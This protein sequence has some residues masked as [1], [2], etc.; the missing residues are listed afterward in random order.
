MTAGPLALDALQAALAT[1]PPAR[2]AAVG[3]ALAQA[4]LT[5]RAVTACFGVAA[6][7]H[8]PRAVAAGR[9]FPASPPPA[10][11]APWLL[12]AGGAVTADAAAAALG[13]ALPA[14]DAAGLVDARDGRVRARVT[15]LPAGSALAVADRWDHLADDAVTPPDDSSHHLVAAL[16]ARRVDRWL[17]LATGAAWAPLAAAGR[18]R[19][20]V[21]ADVAPR[22]IAL[23]RL[24]AALSGH[25][26]DLR[27]T[28]LADGIP[29]RF[30]L[31]T[32]N[33]PIP[34]GTPAA[35]PGEP[36]HRVGGPGLAARLWTTL[37]RLLAPGGEAV[38][39]TAL[40]GDAAPPSLPGELVIARYTPP[41]HP[42]FGV[43]A[44]R[45]ER[46]AGRRVVE[47]AL[48]AAQPHAP[49]AALE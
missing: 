47:V 3:A 16:P 27:V 2:W 24:G 6:V 19:E 23:A 29:G 49:R 22:A 43:V 18:A 26:L 46:P 21:A 32:A 35:R 28:D 42:A 39:H 1:H 5:G 40:E 30:A 8:V 48:T 13:D 34:P 20:V 14:L 36:R 9:R 10:A 11:I 15:V 33:L 4:G 44:W 38:I 12:A 45:P 17:D 37:P 25:A 41:G 31:V 7:A